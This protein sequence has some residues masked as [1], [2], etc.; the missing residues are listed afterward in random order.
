MREKLK[1]FRERLDSLF[2]PLVEDYTKT[3]DFMQNVTKDVETLKIILDKFS[4]EVHDFVMEELGSLRDRL[5]LDRIV[6][7]DVEIEEW[8]NK[9]I[10]LSEDLKVVSLNLS[11]ASMKL[12]REGAALAKVGIELGSKARD[13]VAISRKV[14]GAIGNLLENIKCAKDKVAEFLDNISN[15]SLEIRVPN[16]HFEPGRFVKYLQIHDMA[17][18][19]LDSMEALSEEL[20]RFRRSIDPRELGRAKA[21]YEDIIDR[22]R[23]IKESI[24]GEL[25][26]ASKEIGC[27]VEGLDGIMGSM[28]GFLSELEVR[29]ESFKDILNNVKKINQDLLECISNFQGSLSL[30]EEGKVSLKRFVK[31]INSLRVLSFTEAERVSVYTDSIKPLVRTMDRICDDLIRLSRDASSLLDKAKKVL[32]TSYNISSEASETISSF[33]EKMDEMV[34]SKVKKEIVGG[35]K[36]VLKKLEEIRNG[37]SGLR[38]RNVGIKEELGGELEGFLKYLEKD[39]EEFVKALPQG[40]LT[41]EEFQEGYSSFQSRS[42]IHLEEG[43]I[44]LF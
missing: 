18:Q 25:G 4:R 5:S 8:R 40:I 34:E 14:I 7:L 31:Y 1:R 13:M 15:L 22:F 19:D 3:W 17:S 9:F 39:Y 11:I 28:E 33:E 10:D 41:S 44:E 24:E 43:E 37:L 32:G 27:F 2:I 30:L 35:I 12:G 23:S 36:E 21:Y 42:H 29:I 16:L 38:L 6:T 26:E 20:E